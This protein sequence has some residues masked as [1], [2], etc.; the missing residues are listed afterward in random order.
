MAAVPEAPAKRARTEEP[1][2]VEPEA[3]QTEEP[4]AGLFFRKLNKL[5]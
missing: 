4:A 2:P 5:P 1:E 3:M